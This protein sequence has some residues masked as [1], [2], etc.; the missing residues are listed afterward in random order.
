MLDLTAEAVVEEAWTQDP[1]VFTQL[2][3]E[4]QA[5][6]FS[7]ALNSLRD[8]ALAEEL[9]Q[10]VFLELH[11]RLAS[12]ESRGHARNWLRKVTANRCIDQSR[13]RRVRPQVALDE[14]PEPAA[15]SAAADPM[16]DALL[17]RL[18]A[19]LPEKARMVV[20]L[21]YQE[22]LGLEEIAATVDMPLRAVKG[23]LHR[24]LE[25]LRGKLGRATERR[26]R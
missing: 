15:P 1:E 22:D 26:G 18:V 17:G 6:V 25:I 14:V 19:T 24:G 5:M 12:L 23:H 4:N 7:L 9:A 3:R 10:D 16:R 21:H 8:P 11:R 2:V 13:R 20:I